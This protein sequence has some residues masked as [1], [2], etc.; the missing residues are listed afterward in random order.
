M[1]KPAKRQTILLILMG[2]IALFVLRQYMPMLQVPTE[3]RLQE[4]LREL[5]SVRGDLN[6]ARKQYADRL[7]AVQQ[8]RKLAEPFWIAANG[9]KL[10]QE[11]NAEFSRLTRMAQLSATQK[12]DVARDRTNS[13]LVEVNVS[14]EFKGISMREL[15][16]F[17]KQLRT[18]SH[19]KQLRWEY[20]RIA[21][22]NARTPRNVNCTLRFKIYSLNEEALAF[23]ETGTAE[24]QNTNV[25]AGKNESGNGRK[26]SNNASR[27]TMSRSKK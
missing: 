21:P 27:N 24:S 20:A 12:V 7:E 10:D 8:T 2:I 1:T 26:N 25:G 18:S 13:N 14:L 19:A 5:K 3:G 6:V 23:L 4:K 15:T 22:D 16:G 11:V 9:A 17:F